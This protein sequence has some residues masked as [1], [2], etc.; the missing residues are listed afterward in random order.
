PVAPAPGLVREEPVV[1]AVLDALRWVD[2]DEAALD[3][4]LVSPVAG[5]EPADV[6]RLR[7]SA[8]DTP[9][10]D[11]PQLRP[12]V[13]LRDALIARRR[14][15]DDPAALAF[16]VWRRALTDL[17]TGNEP[18]DQR[19]LD[20]LTAFL[21]DLS[22]RVEANP[23]WSL[24]D[25]L[26]ALDGPD[27][28]ADPWVLPAGPSD[29]VSVVAVAAAAGREWDVVVIAGCVE[30]ELPSVHAHMA[31]FDRALL[32][33]PDVPTV[34][35]RRRRSLDEERRLFDGVAR[36]RAT[37]RT[38]A[39]AA[40]EPGVLI[41]R[42]VEGWTQRDPML[43]PAP[44][45]DAVRRAPTAGT[46]AV[47][48]DGTLRLS[49]SALE[50]YDECP[51][52]YSYE[53]VLGVRSESGTAAELG[54]LTHD[55][56]ETFLDPARAGERP[57]TRDALFELAAEKWTDGIARYAPQREQAWR[58]LGEMLELWWEHEGE[59]PRAPDVAAVEHQFA[60]AVGPHTLRGKIDRVDRVAGGIRIIDYK[61]GTSEVGEDDIPD[62]IQLAVYHL[63][64]VRD[65]ELVALGPPKRLELM[66]LRKMKRVEQPITEDHVEVTEA[67]ILET[68]AKILGES[69]EPVA[70]RHCD[71]CGFQRVCPLWP[72]GREVAG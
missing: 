22:H 1:R 34:A 33:G 15:G 6:R 59:G 50:T 60:V 63:A 52:R 13:A 16:E 2:G 10:I 49:A 43:L 72:E 58:D 9:L 48:P 62:D 5:L 25:A 68:A 24:T 67:R 54:S 27:L 61:T 12:L 57:H 41:S 26:G 66:Y 69:F 38:I 53:Y 40:L 56:L 7:R 42:F 46:G 20:A 39:T 29:A 19:A 21:A 3:R 31:F 8:R 55:I 65:P 44:G 47:F 28:D 37:R 64:A 4:L 30:G 11:Q 18:A 70:G 32:A 35:E 45:P 51:L 23:G 14:A 17:T 71:Y 36:T